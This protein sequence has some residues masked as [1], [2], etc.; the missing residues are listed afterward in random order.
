[1]TNTSRLFDFIHKQKSN[2]PL[3][4]TLNFKEGDTWK[5]YSTDDI[6]ETANKASR[7]L[8]K[9]GVQPGDKIAMV[10]YTNRPEWVIMDIAIQQIGA[11]N[12]PVYPTISV[13]E[14]EYIFNEAAI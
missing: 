4:N 3:K 9:L 12:V 5:P 14:Y 6:I 10:T 8:I 2:H 7:G 1:M 13:G 11:I